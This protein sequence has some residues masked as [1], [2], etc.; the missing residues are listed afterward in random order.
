MRTYSVGLASYSK[1]I[2]L[3][4]NVSMKEIPFTIW[5]DTVKFAFQSQE[6]IDGG[7]QLFF[8]TVEARNSAIEVLKGALFTELPSPNG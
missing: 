5:R 3:T 7:E 1:R 2:M 4:I 8:A 6:N